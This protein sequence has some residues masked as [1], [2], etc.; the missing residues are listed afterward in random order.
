M[1]GVQTCA[2][3]ISDE[4]VPE[5]DATGAASSDA[6][7]SARSG[8]AQHVFCNQCGWENPAGANFCSQCGAQLQEVSGATA[9]APEGTRPVA[10]E[11]PS[12]PD[13]PATPPAEAESEADADEEDTM[14][15]QMGQRLTLLVGGAVL[16]VIGLFFVTLWSQGQEWGS[17]EP[18]ASAEQN[19]APRPSGSGGGAQAPPLSA[20]GG[21]MPTP[22][23]ATLAAQMQSDMPD[24]LAQRVDSVRTAMDAATGQEKRRLRQE[25]ANLYIGAGQT[26]Q[27]AVQQLEIARTTDETDAWRTAA[28]RLYAW[29]QT[30]QQQGQRQQAF[31]VAEETAR[32]YATVVERSPDDLTA[33]TRMGEAYLLTSSPMRGIQT[34]NDVLA[35]D[36]TFVPAHFQ[37]GLALLQIS[38]FEQAIEAFEQVKQFAGDGSPYYRQADRAIQIIRERTTAPS[39]SAPSG[40]AAS[41]S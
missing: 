37:K 23:V 40:G 32:A 15:Q 24:P 28:D 20:G 38:R 5:A 19:E 17:D 21:T 26:G 22:D 2:L 33:Q 14:Q 25:L 30:L 9:S 11:L 16:A 29:M 8:A 1:T 36:S 6:A 7:T 34:I 31:P 41:E 12:A 27:A 3:P 4:S 13:R 39:S 35:T 18:P 10:A